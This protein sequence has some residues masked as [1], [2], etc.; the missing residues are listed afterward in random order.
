MFFAVRVD[1]RYMTVLL[2]HEII[3]LIPVDAKSK[4]AVMTVDV[5]GNER[6]GENGEGGREGL[7]KRGALLERKE[8]KQKNKGRKESKHQKK[9]GVT[10]RD[11]QGKRRKPLHKGEGDPGKKR[12]AIGKEIGGRKEKRERRQR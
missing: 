12:N 6:N 1:D 5:A 4:I 9:D 10:G 3:A 8:Q 11:V 2:Y 7:C